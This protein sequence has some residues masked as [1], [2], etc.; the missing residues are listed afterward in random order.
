MEQCDA[1]RLALLSIVHRAYQ[2]T[3]A[4]VTDDI[5]AIAVKS[6]GY[7]TGEEA[8]RAAYREV[9]KHENLSPQSQAVL[10]S[11]GNPDSLQKTRSNFRPE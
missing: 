7:S 1:L 2:R 5:V 9:D 8:F 4:T 3:G 6:L 11:I 10:G